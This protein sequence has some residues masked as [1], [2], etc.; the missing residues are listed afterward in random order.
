MSLQPCCDVITTKLWYYYNYI[1]TSLQPYRDVITT[2]L[3]I[4]NILRRHDNLIVT[5]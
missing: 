5:S 1:M 3:D 4:I 2:I